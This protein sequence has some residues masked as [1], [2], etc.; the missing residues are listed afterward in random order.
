MTDYM[1]IPKHLRKVYLRRFDEY[2]TEWQPWFMKSFPKKVG[3]GDGSKR[4]WTDDEFADPQGMA[5]IIGDSGEVKP[6]GEPNVTP[7][8]HVTRTFANAFVRKK[9]EFAGDFKNNTLG[10]IHDQKMRNLTRFINR[11][12]EY[13]L[14]QFIYGNMNM[15]S[16]FTNQDLDRQGVINIEAGE[17]NG[18][19]KS[20]LGGQ[21][22]DDKSG[23]GPTPFHDVAYA[24]ER[25]KYLAGQVP[26][27]FFI[28]RK[29]QLALEIDDELLDRKIQIE[30]T[31][32]GVLGEAMMGLTFIKV[33]GQTYKETT[34]ANATLPGMPGAGD[35]S[36]TTWENTNRFDMMTEEVDGTT[37][38]W[39]VI[40]GT[41]QIGEIACGWVDDDHKAERS[42]PTE[43]F[44]EQWETRNPKEVW[45]SAKL[46]A[47]PVVN[48]YAKVMLLRKLA[49]QEI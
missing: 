20:I 35:F 11:A 31:T 44:I 25:Y 37:W 42:R 13:T 36:Q 24:K 34:N 43:I 5:E 41:D 39:G 29:T 30:D 8:S 2:D 15:I 7:I 16:R 45:T 21:A 14:C 47:S 9:R 28:G 1:L 27:R 32:Q 17:F 18:D 12:L 48:D 33:V 46:E 3:P 26:R 19:S 4:Y 6:M 40:T 49:E 23:D 38:E 10:R 22:W